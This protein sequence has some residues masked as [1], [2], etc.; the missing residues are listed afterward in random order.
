MENA[1][2]NFYFTARK[3]S[4]IVGYEIKKYSDSKLQDLPLSMC[5]L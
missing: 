3:C 4:R 2:K 1:Q 5:Y